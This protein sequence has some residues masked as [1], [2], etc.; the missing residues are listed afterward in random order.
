M[1]EYFYIQK[2]PNA[3]GET[4]PA[5]ESGEQF[6]VY[7]REGGLPFII[8]GEVK[9]LPQN[10]WYDEDGVEE[11]VPESGLYMKSYD[12]EVE[13]IYKGANYTSKSKMT[14]FFNYLT[15][16]DGT[17]GLFKIYST[18]TCIGRQNV[19][20]KSIDDDPE[21]VMDDDI[22]VLAVKVTLQV[23]DPVTEVTYNTATQTLE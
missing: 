16:R 18:Y 11:Y 23:N 10:D 19:R 1:R 17:G 14:E 20:L 13:F 4:Y 2:M 15:G 5:Y 22:E 12:M 9:D 8:R 6:D 7:V 3:A 21:F